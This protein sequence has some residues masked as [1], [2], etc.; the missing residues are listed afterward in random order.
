MH[1]TNTYAEDND[2]RK[3]MFLTLAEL[4]IQGELVSELDDL[5]Q[6]TGCEHINDR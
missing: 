2:K 3:I 1:R 5:F 4:T 6:I